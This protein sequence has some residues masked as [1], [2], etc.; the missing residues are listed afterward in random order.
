MGLDGTTLRFSREI[1]TTA[2]DRP[3]D[4]GAAGRA[5]AGVGTHI[6]SVT[7]YFYMLVI[8]PEQLAAIEAAAITRLAEGFAD[9]FALRHPDRATELGDA[10]RPIACAA[11]T[12]AVSYGIKLEA[13]VAAFVDLALLIHPHF[14]EHPPIHAVLTDPGIP[15]DLRVALAIENV[16]RNEWEQAA[17]ASISS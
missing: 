14:D 17:C 13:D 15:P 6:E 4:A 11:A 5:P 7:L 10:R 3:D 16:S 8:R 1:A 2:P 9:E 12:R